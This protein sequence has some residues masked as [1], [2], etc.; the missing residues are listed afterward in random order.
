MRFLSNTSS[1]LAE[2][3][4]GNGNGGLR[5]DRYFGDFL[6]IFVKRMLQTN[7]HVFFPNFCNLSRKSQFLRRKHF[8]MITLIPETNPIHFNN[9]YNAGFV[10][11]KACMYVCS[12]FLKSFGN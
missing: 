8:K 11:C 5:Y 2:T 12:V 7:D 3:L 4:L 9:I 1:T 10:V 6:Q